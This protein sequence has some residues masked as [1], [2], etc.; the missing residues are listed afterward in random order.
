MA[1][2]QGGSW[3]YFIG[4]A[5]LFAGC[6]AVG[7]LSLVYWD[8]WLAQRR[9]AAMLGPGSASAAE[10]VRA[11]A[12][13]PGRRLALFI[14][15]RIGSAGPLEGARHRPVGGRGGRSP[16]LVLIVGFARDNAT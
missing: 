12:L 10:F 1:A 11:P 3:P 8:R 5:A 14:V 15:A 6:L 9:A 4:L 16:T 13:T 2:A 7:L